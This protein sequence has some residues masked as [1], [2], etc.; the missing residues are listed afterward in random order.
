MCDEDQG[1]AGPPGGVS[2][3]I[4]RPVVDEPEIVLPAWAPDLSYMTGEELL[5]RLMA[6]LEVEAARIRAQ[7]PECSERDNSCAP[8]PWSE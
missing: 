4:R 2:E 5:D 8:R 7:G 1:A 6:H 3:E